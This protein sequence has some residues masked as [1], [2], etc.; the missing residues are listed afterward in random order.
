MNWEFV[1]D[2][3]KTKREGQSRGCTLCVSPQHTN[4]GVCCSDRTVKYT[5]GHFVVQFNLHFHVLYFMWCRCGPLH[6]DALVAYYTKLQVLLF[7]SL[8]STTINLRWILTTS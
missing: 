8:V 7:V 4:C 1:V 6:L 3:L 2:A 5:V